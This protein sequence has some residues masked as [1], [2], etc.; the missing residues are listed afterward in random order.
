M[1]L[2]RFPHLLVSQLKLVS[3]SRTLAHKTGR[4]WWFGILV[5]MA[6]FSAMESAM[7]RPA[8]AA[9]ELRVAIKDGVSQVAVGSSTKAI[10][11]DS[12]GRPL[13]EIA[14]M[15]AFIAQP[16]QGNVSLDRW[17]SGLIWVEPTDGGYVYI[18][19][20][21]YRG[22]TLVAPSKSGL[23]AVN[24]VDLEQYL[25]SV[26]GGEMNGN[27][28]QEALKAQAV[29]ARSYALYHRQHA[30][31]GLYDVVDTTA[32]QVY[33]GIKDESVGTQMAVNAT[34]E[35]VLISG[36]QIVEAVFHSSAGGCTENSENVWSKPMP[37]L[38]SVREGFT[39]VSPVAQWEIDVPRTEL[40]KRI[41]G[42]GNIVSFQPISTTP[43]GRIVSM[44]VV[45]DRGRK[46]ISGEALQSALNLKSTLF[47]IVA[48][49]VLEASKDKAQTSPTMFQVIGRGFGHGLGLSQW[50]AYNLAQG[51]YNYQQIL[52]YYYQNT[53][54][55]KIQVK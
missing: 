35:Q 6:A 41:G 20:N 37:Y 30:R 2:E 14:P 26:L 34:A 3:Q 12:S 40:S 11:R 10:V 7:S 16:K 53:N 23:T 52:L 55:A 39:E 22:R 4:I 25:Y 17:Q 5:C 36:G 49:P 18:G 48:Q 1:S 8:E 47:N 42:V 19:E 33:R 50:G 29:A 28:P 51:N 27:W 15:N 54:L 43:C 24:Y 32:S 45:G 9:L 38:K 44:Q 13:G 31:N 21:W 46:T